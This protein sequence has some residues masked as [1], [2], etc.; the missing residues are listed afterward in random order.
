M[1]RQEIELAVVKCIAE[2]LAIDSKGIHSK[3]L[4][5]DELGAD[6]LDFMDIMFHFE[7]AF[8]IKMQREDLDFLARIDLDREEA[9]VDE[10]L[11]S[12]AKQQLC[13]WMPDLAVD[14]ALKP[15]DLSRFLSIESLTILVE[16]A[17]L[18]HNKGSA[19]S[20]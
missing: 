19:L 17:L 20:A 4:L 3:S 12:A 6:S 11:T 10:F 15:V 18:E 13:K 16:A 14:E 5:I 9:V 8:K 7:D 2:S 1:K